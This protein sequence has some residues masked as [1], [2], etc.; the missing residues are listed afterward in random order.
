MS[1]PRIRWRIK[2][3][4]NTNIKHIRH[5]P[6]QNGTWSRPKWVAP[7]GDVRDRP[8]PPNVWEGRSESYD[9]IAPPFLTVDPIPGKTW[10]TCQFLFKECRWLVWD[11]P[12]LCRMFCSSMLHIFALSTS[13]S[14][15]G[16]Q[17]WIAYLKLVQYKP[18]YWVRW[19]LPNVLQVKYPGNRCQKLARGGLNAHWV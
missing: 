18:V 19:S 4:K 6:F 11:R 1:A 16:V 10:Y 15:E 12:N 3:V 5:L 8:G 14:S 7:H 2:K 9:G 17:T 13:E